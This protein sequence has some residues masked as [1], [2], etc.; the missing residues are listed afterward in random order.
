MLRLMECRTTLLLGLLANI[1]NYA[2][3]AGRQK[4]SGG[5]LCGFA[6]ANH[7]KPQRR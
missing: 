5:V 2:K 1:N 6:V 7:I 4:V 3:D